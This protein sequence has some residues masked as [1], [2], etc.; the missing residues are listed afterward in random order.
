MERLREDG[1]GQNRSLFLAKWKFA[2]G[3]AQVLT[4]ANSWGLLYDK[5]KIKSLL[6]KVEYSQEF[7]EIFPI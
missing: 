1:E 6:T 7:S 5:K 2:N 4:E 3:R